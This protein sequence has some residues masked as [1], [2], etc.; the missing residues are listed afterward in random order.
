VAFQPWPARRP[1]DASTLRRRDGDAELA[2]SLSLLAATLESTA[3]GILV[4][5]AAGRVVGRNEK[6]C[7]MWRVP[8]DEVSTDPEG[9]SNATLMAAVLEQVSDPA[10]FSARIEEIHAN[11]HLVATDEIELADGRVFSRYTQP[12]LIDGEVVG[13]VW[14]FRDRTAERRLE[15][16]LRRMAYTDELTGLANRALFMQRG[17][18][19][20]EAAEATGQPLGVAV[21]DLDNLKLVNDQLGHR[22]GDELIVM[23]GARLQGAARAG[24]LVARLG[25]DEFGV[26][27]PA[28]P[29][30]TVA[31]VL[32]RM[33]DV[34]SAPL[35]LCGRSVRTTISGGS[36]VGDAAANGGTVS[37]ENLLHQA[38]LAMY[39]AKAEGRGRVRAYDEAVSRADPRTAAAEVARLLGDPDGL[40]TVMQPICELATGVLVGHE[41]LSRFPGRDHREVGEWFALAR[42]GEHGPA[43]EARALRSALTGFDPARGTYLTVNVSPSV[44]GS[45]AVQ[46][47]LAGD[48]TGVVV[49]VTEDSRLDLGEL[50]RLLDQLRSRGARVAMDDTGAG[51]DGLR[52]LVRLRPEIVKLDRELVHRVHVHPEKRALV[53]ALVS[54]CRQTGASL[55]AE[56]IESVE[57]LR[58]LA[59]L[60]VHLGQGWFVGR[61]TTGRPLVSRAAAEACG[62]IGDVTPGDLERLRDHLDRAVT[63]YDIARAAQRSLPA[64]QA[65]DLLLSLVHG[66]ELVVADR[67]GWTVVEQRYDLA[68]YPATRECLEAG[69][70]VVVRTDDPGADPAEVRALREQ[71]FG[72]VLVLPLRSDGRPTGIIEVF[73]RAQRSWSDREMRVCR[74][75]ADE[76]ADALDR[77]TRGA[78]PPS[79]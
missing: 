16:G 41:A 14:S 38:D 7:R 9:P 27:L 78:P 57:E 45:P 51:Y 72:S 79:R 10:A 54:F 40:V 23:A 33:A 17:R 29:P 49:E 6:F 2:A 30:A 55:C 75:L 68:D 26:L 64:L 39:R 11:P 74:Y 32:Q 71:G 28:A 65:D 66:D 22:S 20:A 4:V 61:P 63:V 35:V 77:I 59:D 67:P 44:L 43:L 47:V 5:S 46:E 53:E 25:G 42:S 70:P 48:L 56:G 19:M 37:L 36:S 15:Q 1:R 13:R 24:D 31:A 34:M 60:G 73:C 3:D 52:R 69:V 62:S 8:P 50:D 12:Q 18:A 76:V 21:L 58:T